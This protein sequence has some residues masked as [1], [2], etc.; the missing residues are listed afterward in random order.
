MRAAAISPCLLPSSG[1]TCRNQLV[2]R[3][4]TNLG[5]GVDGTIHSIH[6]VFGDVIAETDGTGQ[7]TREYIWI[8]NAGH[9]GVSLPIAVV[10]RNA[11]G[12]FDVFSVHTDHVSRPIM[13][14]SLGQ[15]V[16]WQAEWGPF[17]ASHSIIGSEANDQ[18]F[19]GAFL[20]PNTR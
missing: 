13:M 8:P 12:R 2:S 7:T 9:A 5:A 11:G 6:G 10:N 3:T 1:R 4:L 17:G 16:V 15:V 14:T 19:P 20:L 18:R